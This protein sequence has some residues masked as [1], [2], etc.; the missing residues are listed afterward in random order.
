MKLGDLLEQ[1][2]IITTEKKYKKEELIRELLKILCNLDNLEN[3]D[4]ILYHLLEREKLGSTAIGNGVAIPH[5]RI[6]NVDKPHILICVLKKVVDFE[7]SDKRP[8]KL[9]FLIITPDKDLTLH[10]NLLA[11]VSHIIRD[12]DFL[13]RIFQAQDEKEAYKIL[14]EEE[15]KL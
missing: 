9:V 10:L 8:V 7:A 11:Q 2:H 14:L 5:V 12:T 1:N 4:E 3:Y 15:S 13:K 6:A